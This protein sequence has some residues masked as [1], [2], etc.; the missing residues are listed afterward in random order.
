MRIV[1]SNVSSE[2]TA[3]SGVIFF[4]P[5]VIIWFDALSANVSGD[6]SALSLVSKLS[7]L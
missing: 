5:S 3:I 1:S 7:L 4:S 6:P 2:M